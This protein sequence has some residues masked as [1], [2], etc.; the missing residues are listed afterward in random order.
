LRIRNGEID[1]GSWVPAMPALVLPIL[2]EAS[3]CGAGTG[4]GSCSSTHV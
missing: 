4:C 3:G 2:Q 1:V